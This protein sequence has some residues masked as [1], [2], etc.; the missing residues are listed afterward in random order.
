MGPF[1]GKPLSS[2]TVEDVRRLIDNAVCESAHLDYKRELSIDNPEQ[3]KEFLRDVS[4]FANA[5]GGTIIY[6]V[7]EERDTDGKPTGLP[8]VVEGFNVRNRDSFVLT[9]DQLLKDGIDERLPSYELATVALPIAKLVVMIRVPASL[10]APHMVTFGRDRRFFMRGNSGR[11]EMSTA[12]IRD[13]VLHADGVVQR[14]ASFVRE[15]LGKFV[16]HAG[17]GPFWM[18]HIVPLIRR[19]SA[20]D[21]TDSNVVLRLMGVAGTLGTAGTVHC[22]EGFKT[23]GHRGVDGR[24]HMI[25]FRDGGLEFFDQY[26]FVRQPEE[27][28]FA[29][30]HFENLAFQLLQEGLG[31]YREGRIQLPAAVCVSMGGISGYSIPPVRGPRRHPPAV[32]D[33]VIVDPILLL[34]IPSD[35]KATLRPAL[36]YV[37]N[38][39]GWQRC[40]GYNALGKY[41]GYS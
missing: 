27:R 7:D 9:V 37:W 8:Q 11:Q 40:E 4:A 20:L 22:V 13:S 12:Q 26:A 24:S 2:V 18:M 17:A 32:E 15:R 3:R 25:A 16:S 33:E 14:V 28:F 1:S 5:H 31:L 35:V 19:P 29:V 30:G 6:G 23:Y 41:V 34:D 21:V 10:R 39:F 36:D 38:A